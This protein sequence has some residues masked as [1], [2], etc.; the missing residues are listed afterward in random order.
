MVDSLIS[1]DEKSKV[2]A[3]EEDKENK[4]ILSNNLILFDKELSKLEGKSIDS[5]LSQ[6]EELDE[7]MEEATDNEEEGKLLFDLVKQNHKDR[8]R[9]IDL[10]LNPKTFFTPRDPSC[11]HLPIEV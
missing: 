4:E 8:D 3:I 7:E 5:Q 6:L 1:L 11:W 2:T 9:I 10:D